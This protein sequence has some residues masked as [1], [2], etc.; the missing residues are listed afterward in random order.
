MSPSLSPCVRRPETS[1]TVKEKAGDR[2]TDRF[3]GS[4]LPREWFADLWTQ[5][6]ELLVFCVGALSN[7]T[8]TRVLTQ[9]LLGAGKGVAVGW[10]E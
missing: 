10:S 3:T 7:Q 5:L 9:P 6:W 4:K 1:P 8:P 2:R